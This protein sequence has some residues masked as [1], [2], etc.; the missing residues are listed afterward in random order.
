MTSHELK[1]T[2]KALRAKLDEAAKLANVL[3]AQGYAIEID[4]LEHRGING[5]V[6]IAIVA[7]IARRESL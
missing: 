5:P 3:R 2:A 6:E 1:D 4:T 7:S